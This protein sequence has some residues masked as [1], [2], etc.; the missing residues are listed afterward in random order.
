MEAPLRAPSPANPANL[1]TL[2]RLVLV[3]VFAVQALEGRWGWA[4]AAFATASAT[5][6][7]DGWLARAH[8]WVTPLGVFVDPLADKALQLAAFTLLACKGL[9]PAW[10]A[11]LA[12][13]R[14]SIVVAGFALVAL[15]ADIP[16]VRASFLGKLG[17]FCQMGALSLLLGLHAFG[18]APAAEPRADLLLAGAVLLNFA[19]GMDYAVRGLAGGGGAGAP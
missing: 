6:F 15:V 4:F 3:P 7:L 17:T 10:V 19:A 16:V 11:V 14:E 1:L 12:W 9:C 8:G 18:R 2:L 13:A 5:D